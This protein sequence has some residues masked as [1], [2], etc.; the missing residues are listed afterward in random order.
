M[1]DEGSEHDVTLIDFYLHSPPPRFKATV[2][3][4]PALF[5]SSKWACVQVPAHWDTSGREGG[6]VA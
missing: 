6:G 3:L 4:S 5:S 2:K 1:L